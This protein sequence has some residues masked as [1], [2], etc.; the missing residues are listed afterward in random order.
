MRDGS[1][2][3][4]HALAE[5]IDFPIPQKTHKERCCEAVSWEFPLMECFDE[6]RFFLPCL[7]C[8]FPL[9]R[10]CLGSRW[11]A[12]AMK[13]TASTPKIPT[14]LILGGKATVL[15][16]IFL[17]STRRLVRRSAGTLQALNA[18]GCSST[19]RCS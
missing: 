6:T 16:M 4:D 8:C 15:M 9:R 11:V 10:A 19:R 1:V 5:W 7:V 14:C 13:R 17:R 18:S 3:S 2:L 12:S